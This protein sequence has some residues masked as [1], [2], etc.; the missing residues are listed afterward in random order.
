MKQEILANLDQERSEPSALGQLALS[1]HLSAYPKGHPRY[2]ATLDEEAE[3]VKGT[4][5]EDVKAFHQR[6]YGASFAELAFVGDFD[7]RETQALLASLLGDWRS[8]VPYCRMPRRI[9]EAESLEQVLLTPDK[10]NAFFMGGMNLALQDT[11]P[12]YPALV[13]GDFMLGGGFLNSR[14]ATRIRQKEGLS[15]SVGSDLQA[16][17]R[18]KAGQWSFY[19]ICAPQ[20]AA[21]LETALREELDKVLRDGFTEDE[22]RA[23]KQGWLQESM[24]SRAEDR[25]LVAQLGMDLDTGR[26]MAH[27]AELERS[28]LALTSDQIMAAVRKYLVP[29]RLSIVKAGDF[30]KS[31][32][33]P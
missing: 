6:F 10:A 29:A 16:A 22:I 26:S 3:A 32:G 31:G 2:V 12:E 17:A 18:E 30:K 13:L 27:R 15:Y 23:A 8:P 20:N 11:D 9:R 7:P 25:E 33:N 4:T 28:L 24:L 1:R 21:R 5:L 19:A 14:L